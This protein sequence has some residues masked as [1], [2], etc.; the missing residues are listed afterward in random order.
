MESAYFVQLAFFVFDVGV[1]C[2]R[3][4]FDILYVQ[5]MCIV[6]YYIISVMHNIN[7]KN[8][9]GRHCAV[10]ASKHKSCTLMLYML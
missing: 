10:D 7:I 2:S 5:Y 1:H 3:A 6:F 4:L 9:F 8:C